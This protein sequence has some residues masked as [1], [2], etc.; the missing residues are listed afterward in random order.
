MFD[1]FVILLLSKVFITL[2]IACAVLFLSLLI[3]N[4]RNTEDDQWRDPQ[5]VIFRIF[6]PLVQLFSHHVRMRMGQPFFERTHKK[7][8]HSGMTYSLLPEEMITLKIIFAS[9]TTVFAFFL[10]REINSFEARILV[11]G[12]PV[13]GFF[14]PDIWLRDRRVLRQAL[15]EKQFPFLLD[16]LVLSMRAGMNY[17]TSLNQTVDSLPQ[18]PVKEEFLRYLRELKAGKNRREALDSLSDRMGVASVNNF[19]AALKQADET[20]GEIGDVLKA[21]AA[22]RRIERFNN[23][24]KKANQA[25]VK[26]LLPLIAF[27]FPVLFM[28]IIFVMATKAVDSG[29]A[30]FWLTRLLTWVII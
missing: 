14:F 22:Q 15:I 27:L 29:I 5:P 10:F 25:P 12:L 20:G 4:R 16:L 1:N 24:E 26:M 30:P 18:G 21:Q 6:K 2:S 13:L 23:A 28:I 8:S 7:I 17:A 3:I 19:V 11:F 9:I